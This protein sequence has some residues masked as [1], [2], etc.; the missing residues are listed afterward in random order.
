MKLRVKG[1]SLR[2]RLSKS[3]VTRLAQS[4]ALK[5]TVYFGSASE[6]KLSYAL[7]VSSSS[8]RLSIG[9]A[10]QTVTVSI[11]TKTIAHWAATETEVG[12][13]GSV[14]V[15]REPLDILIEKDFACLD[16]SEE[17][18][19]DTFPNPIACLPVSK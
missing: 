3:E 9:Y 15:G 14:D 1:N 7:N 13:Y 5:E 11:D 10:Q 17:E 6:A 19:R 16:A 2:F 4:E 12:I 8:E 18:N